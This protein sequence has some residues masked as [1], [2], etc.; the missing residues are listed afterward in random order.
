MPAANARTSWL[1]AVAVCVTATTAAA[2]P[3]LSDEDLAKKNVGSYFT[4]LPLFN[5]STDTGFGFGARAYYYYDGT[6]DDPRFKT[7]PYL[8]RVFLQ[9]FVS[10][11]GTQFHWLDFDAPKIADSPYRIRSQLIYERNTA[12]NYFGLGDVSLQ[13]LRFPGSTQSFGNFNDYDNALTAVANG[14]TF[15][16]YNQYDLL[17]PIW[18]ASVERLFFH[19]RIRALAGFGFSYTRIRDYTGEQVDATDAMGNSTMATEAP[20]KLATDC[21]LSGQP[22]P[23]VIVGCG[24][25]WDNFLRFGVSY[26]TRDFEPDPKSGA[27]IDAALDVGTIVLGS[28]YDYARA[29]IAARG[30]WRPFPQNIVFAG[31]AVVEYESA[32]TPFFSMDT[33]PFTDD[34]RN[35]LGGERTLRGYRQDRFVGPVMTLLNGEVR[36]TFGHTTILNQK[37]GFFLVPF[38][39]LGRPYNSLSELTYKD[40]RPSY[41]GAFRISWN[42]ATIITV[43]VGVSPEDVGYYVNFNHMF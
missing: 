2:E 42:L 7:T 4:G 30:Y 34:P 26:D 11:G 39:D 31:R 14:Q 22:G 6:R 8:Y 37:F 21:G 3:S 36:W 12:Q 9:A 20:T 28:Q 17:R 23:A 16:R 32:G 15:S 18:I 5:Y 33:F 19:D 13:P 41:G 1:A 40:W 24:G 10:T 43:D 29:M 35:G 27:F 38:L 25:G